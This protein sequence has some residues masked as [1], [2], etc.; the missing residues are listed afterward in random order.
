MFIAPLAKVAR[1]ERKRRKGEANPHSRTMVRQGGYAPHSEE[2]RKYYENLL[3]DLRRCSPPGLVGEDLEDLA[4]EVLAIACAKET[5]DETVEISYARKHQQL[6]TLL[7]VALNRSTRDQLLR[8]GSLIDDFVV[9]SAHLHSNQFN[10]NTSSDT[11]R[12]A[13]YF[14]ESELSDRESSHHSHSSSTDED[15]EALEIALLAGR[16]AQPRKKVDDAGRKKKTSA[17]LMKEDK[18]LTKYAYEPNIGA[19]GS[20]EIGEGEGDPQ[21]RDEE[22]EE[23]FE[24]LGDERW[25]GMEGGGSRGGVQKRHAPIRFEEVACNGQ[26]LTDCLRR[27]FPSQMTEVCASQAVKVEEYLGATSV[28]TMTVETQL[29]AFL[30][31]YDDESVMKWIGDLCASRWEVFYGLQRSKESTEKERRAVMVAMEQHARKD[32]TVENLYQRLTGKEVDWLGKKPLRGEEE[33]NAGRERGPHGRRPLRRVDLQNC[34]FLGERNPHAHKRATVPPKTQKLVYE[35]HDEVALPPS[36]TS[37]PTD[38]LVSIASLPSWSR[39]AFGKL[40]HLNAMQSKAFS[41]AFKS[42]ENM[43]VSAP[44]GAGKTN[45]ALLAMLRAVNNAMNKET[46]VI[47]LHE[48]KM[49]YVAPMKALVQ[50]VVRTFTERLA[51][52]G[53]TV[54]ELSGDTATTQAQLMNAQLIVATPEKWDIVTRKS[55]ELGVASLLKLLIIDEVHLLHNERGAV[56]E[57]IVARTFLQQQFMGQGGIRLVGLSA[58]LPNW[59][60]VASFLQVNQ[61]RALFV[62]DSRYRP[63]PLQQTYC[64]VKKI[65]GMTQVVISNNIVYDKVMAGIERGEQTIV[66]VHSRKDT[67]FTAKFILSH[68]HKELRMES[69]VQPG[70]ETERILL[71]AVERERLCLALQQLIPHGCGIHHAGLRKEE[72]ALVEELFAQRHLKVLVC[73]S[74]LAWGVNLPANQVIIKGTRVFN[75]AKGESELLSA[76]DVLQMFGRAGRAGFGSFTIGRAAIVTSAEDLQYYLCVLNAQLPIESHLMKR[77]VDMLNAEIVLGHV[78][79]TSEGV[80]WLQRTYLYV[81]MKQAPELYGTR[82]T[83]T[84]PLFLHYLECVVHTCCEELRAANM[85]QYD[86]LTRRVSP[87]VY[88]RI[89][90]YYYISAVSMNAFKDNVRHTMQDADIFRVFALSSEFSQIAVRADEQAQ[91]RELIDNAPV[92]VRESRY[93]PL[94]K[95][96]ILLQ[97][98]ISRKS[99]EGLP[100][101]SEIGYVKDS[102][103]R[104][105]RG[106]YEICVQK[107]YGRTTQQFLELFLMVLHQ[108]WIVETPIRQ[109]ADRILSFKDAQSILP[110]MERMRVSWE[111]MRFWSLE[112]WEEKL[113]DD[114]RARAAME[115]V[116]V[117]PHYV[118]EA[119]IRPLTRA[120]MYVD[121][122]ITPDFVFS[123]DIHQPSHSVT[124][125]LLLIE[126]SNGRILHSETV[127]LPQAC[128]EGR[129]TYSCPPV[130][131]PI[132][133]PKPTHW[134]V[135][136]LSPHWLHATSSTSVC[137]MNLFL[138][139][140]APPLRDAPHWRSGSEEEDELNVMK[141]MGK[142]QLHSLAEAFFPFTH[143]YSYQREVVEALLE[144]EDENVFVGVP[145]GGGKTVLAEIFALQFI[146]QATAQV[147]ENANK[148]SGTMEDDNTE[149]GQTTGEE[150]MKDEM[151]VE[152]GGQEKKK[153]METISL[154]SQKKNNESAPPRRQGIIVSSSPPTLLYLTVHEDTATRHFLDWSYRFG[155]LLQVKVKQLSPL[156]FY[157][158]F[159]NSHSERI[160]ED[161]RDENESVPNASRPQI[162][163]AT[164]ANLISLLRS[165]FSSVSSLLLHGVTHIV[166]DHL[167]LLRSSEGRWV[168]EC[169]ARLLHPPYLVGKG[170]RRARLLALSYPLISTAEVC[171]WL[172][173]SSLRQFNWSNTC[174]QLR[175]RVEGSEVP[176]A[177]GRY[178]SGVIAA[179]KRLQR[180]QYAH[181]PSVIF[182]PNEKDAVEVATRILLRCRRPPHDPLTSTGSPSIQGKRLGSR[183]IKSPLSEEVEDRRLGLL[184]SAGV[185][186]FHRDTSPRDEIVL[187]EKLDSGVEVEE[188]SKEEGE[189]GEQDEEE[190]GRRRKTEDHP[191][192]VYPLILVCTFGV[193]GRLPAGAFN[194]AVIAT[195][196]RWINFAFPTS[197]SLHENHRSGSVVSSRSVDEDGA[198][199]SVRSVSAAELL[200]MISRASQEAVVHCPKGRRWVWS[201]LL[202]EPL[203]LESSLRYPLDFAD[204]TN[205]A[206]VKGRVRYKM[207]VLRLL[208]H[209]YFLFHLKSNPNFYGVESAEDIPRYASALTA[210]IVQCLEERGCIHVEGEKKGEDNPHAIL[211][212]LPRGVAL[213]RYAISMESV[214]ALDEHLQS[215]LSSQDTPVTVSSMWQMVCRCFKELSVDELGDVARC[216]SSAEREALF[217]IAR[218]LPPKFHVSFINLDFNDESIKLFLL[219]LAL[220]C[221]FFS[222]SDASLP[223]NTSPSRFAASTFLHP[224][225]KAHVPSAEL[226]LLLQIPEEIASRFETDLH[227]LLPPIRRVLQ[228]CVSLLVPSIYGGLWLPVRYLMHFKQ[229]VESH[230]WLDA[231][232]QNKK[233]KMFTATGS[234]EVSEVS[235]TGHHDDPRM[236]LGA[237]DNGGKGGGMEF[238]VAV[239]ITLQEYD[240]EGK[241]SINLPQVPPEGTLDP[242]DQVALQPSVFSSFAPPPTVSGSAS[243]PPSLPSSQGEEEHW[244]LSCVVVEKNHAEPSSLSSTSSSSTKVIHQAELGTTSSQSRVLAIKG[245]TRISGA[246]WRTTLRF[247]LS[248]LDHFNL[249]EVDLVAV[250]TSQRE[251]IDVECVVV[252]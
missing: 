32:S 54:A 123:Q 212:P 121:I 58:T 63:I 156:S 173:I 177:R 27:L 78:E 225:Q 159:D 241:E 83:E 25:K 246:E 9:D 91:L 208:Q 128:V 21:W 42:D 22:D 88:G 80:R 224:F 36:I 247:P 24:F 251:H 102:A 115:A 109:V 187:L 6:E 15:D 12:N 154:E 164:G 231:P 221:G 220:C 249:E 81:R 146:L 106:L 90:S 211:V 103:Q 18:K 92:A 112:D 242:T 5:N 230:R 136:C 53:L 226:P 95:I 151:K 137:L 181:L 49:V 89:A 72:R 160:S 140:I 207:D 29:T 236:G 37:P 227:T 101:M 222:F 73:T 68:A 131:V 17:Q 86:P 193:A 61:E 108:Q 82:R 239:I 26:Y 145:P 8:Y 175:V 43:L 127:L 153:S 210:R 96:N 217:T 59:A 70:S 16:P 45:V 62:F 158:S 110:V 133:E 189:A 170:E 35:T 215:A 240:V 41:C 2:T 162:L 232:H 180:P 234:V 111:E 56:L 165:E 4:A 134:M 194:L 157:S 195:T 172:R 184:L 129:R 198:D 57:A 171:R 176:S 20:E 244:W 197:L 178:E 216:C 141:V 116:Q 44:T 203:P 98:F 39:E 235:A 204:S 114:R 196:E 46:G 104:I 169:L 206:I 237:G 99:L 233:V 14:M 119:S 185:G 3:Q 66:F 100:L 182:V 71:E 10:N 163:V 125:L 94:A 190:E 245:L 69:I 218:V 166:V 143:F 243:S 113:S 120:M 117:V 23:G 200:Q 161:E 84:D 122:D 118:V 13:F 60:D 152:S 77:V 144:C 48:L 149:K 209:H 201:K 105:L 1:K 186:Y 219:P 55:V 75:S 179:V 183:L 38:D 74:T 130:V 191:K 28:D 52:L 138:P 97:C 85:V 40:S 124:E 107:E 238:V 250:L 192:K 139:A 223:L 150:L 214:E 126:H 51:P 155:T 132:T 76:L 87:T 64:A 148:E 147:E 31:G 65:P 205:T 7:D 67:A 142:Y 228:G 19:G 174:R 47:C 213:S 188:E 248:A 33:E 34:V 252:C 93:T 11:Q 30:G 168:E 167:H 199:A 229:C 79:S 50:E 135:R 202:N